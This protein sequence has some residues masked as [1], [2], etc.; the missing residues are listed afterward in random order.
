MVLAVIL[1]TLDSRGPVS[2]V[3]K[4]FGIKH[5]DD[6]RAQAPHMSADAL[7][8]SG[9]NASRVDYC[10]AVEQTFI[11]HRANR[12]IT[13]WL[14]LTGGPASLIFSKKPQRVSRMIS[15]ISKLNTGPRFCISKIFFKTVQTLFSCDNSS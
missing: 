5:P 1:V 6:R 9:R 12:A 11:R 4:H 10:D 14:T 2:L 8:H 3:H 15:T 7:I 13:E